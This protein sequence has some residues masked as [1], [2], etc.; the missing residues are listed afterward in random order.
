VF[1]GGDNGQVSE[2]QLDP[3]VGF[4]ER[5]LSAN[6]SSQK[7]KRTDHLGSSGFLSRIIPSFL[8]FQAKKSVVQIKIDDSRNILYALCQFD[9]TGIDQR[10]VDLYDLG[11]WGNS[12]KL[13]GHVR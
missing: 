13:I 4:M 1:T 12:F 11:S 10:I 5:L 3:K 2:L 9:S 8:K 6:M 7:L